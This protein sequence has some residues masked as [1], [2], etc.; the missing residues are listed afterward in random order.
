MLASNTEDSIHERYL[1]EKRYE[2]TNHLG[3]VLVVISDRLYN[4]PNA[5]AT[6]VITNE[7]DIIAAQDYD[8]FGMHLTGRN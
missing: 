3:S 4:I 1:G 6:A 5:A 2:L 8:P 7:P